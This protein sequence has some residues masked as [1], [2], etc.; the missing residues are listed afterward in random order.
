[1]SR[2]GATTGS[3]KRNVGSM[4]AMTGHYIP[5][6]GDGIR[7]CPVASGT[8]TSGGVVN[9]SLKTKE[10]RGTQG[11]IGWGRRAR[12]RRGRKNYRQMLTKR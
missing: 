5:I 2:K 12:K 1:M 3:P 11:K 9:P 7:S 8:E 6:T 10:E 4:K